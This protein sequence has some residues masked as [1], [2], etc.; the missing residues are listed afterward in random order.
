MTQI[1]SQAEVSQDTNQ[2]IPLPSVEK[3]DSPNLVDSTPELAAWLF[4]K[5]N[6]IAAPSFTEIKIKQFKYMDR[7]VLNF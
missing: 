4:Q 2:Q 1:L 7:I 6:R 5:V 3:E